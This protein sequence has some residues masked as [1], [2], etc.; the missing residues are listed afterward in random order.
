[1]SAYPVLYQAE[2]I[3]KRNRLTVFFRGFMIIPHV[4]LGMFL[5]I[6]A[7]FTAIAAWV[8][9]SLTGKYPAG[10]YDFNANVVRWSGRLNA[11]AYLQ[12]DAFPPFGFDDD[13]NYPVRVQFAGPL[14][15]YSRLKAF[16]RLILAI[17]VYIIVYALQIVYTLCAVV[18]WF[19]AVITGKLP[20]GLH[21]GLDLGLS[22]QLKGIAYM[23]FL[24]T[25]SYPPFSNENPTLSG[26]ESGGPLLSDGVFAP[27]S[28]GEFATPSQG[29]FAPPSPDGSAPPREDNFAPPTERTDRQDG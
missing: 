19:V 14:P 2:Y 13:P 27:S 5:G 16:F 24:L 3:E 20:K 17:P 28:Q 22:Y 23:L 15:E 9:V 26:A 8:M 29:D 25:E 12:V 11:Y 7:F 18:A 10:L 1:M 6:A 21:D 4:I